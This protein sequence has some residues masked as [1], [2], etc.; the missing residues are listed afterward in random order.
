MIGLVRYI[1]K[2]HQILTSSKQIRF[3]DPRIIL[4]NNY[5]EYDE[6]FT[7]RLAL[8]AADYEMFSFLWN[9]FTQIYGYVHLREVTRYLN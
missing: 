8:K 6:T 2:E 4:L 7:L 1:L 9:E 3:I 5:D